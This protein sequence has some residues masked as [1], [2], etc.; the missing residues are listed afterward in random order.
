MDMVAC[1]IKVRHMLLTIF[2]VTH[3]MCSCREIESKAMACASTA[4]GV[5][6]GAV[7]V[8]VAQ[9]GAGG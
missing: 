8:G 3:D 1:A 2:R 5:L 6:S 4:V 7:D 9:R